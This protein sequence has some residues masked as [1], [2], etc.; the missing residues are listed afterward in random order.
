MMVKVEHV[1]NIA[2][3]IL[4]CCILFYVSFRM[5]STLS[6]QLRL[7]LNGKKTNAVVKKVWIYKGYP[8]VVYEFEVNGIKYQGEKGPFPID[9]A[10]DDSISITYL[11]SNPEIN[12][13]SED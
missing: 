13:A 8:R 12:M 11:L 4:G 6:T 3:I 9:I 1:K 10:I 7:Q 2:Y 5:L